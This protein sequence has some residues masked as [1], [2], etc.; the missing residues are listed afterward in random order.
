MAT[1]RQYIC[2]KCGPENAGSLFEAL[3]DKANGKL[4]HCSRCRTPYESLKLT[5][6]LGLGAK[7]PVCTVLDCFKPRRIESWPDGE[8]NKVKFYPFLVILQRGKKYAIWLPYWHRVINIKG[9]K[10]KNKYGQWAPL[11]YSHLFQ[12]LMQQ[13]REKGYDKILK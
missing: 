11:M 2:K 9:Q 8:E 10:S 13:A 4:L 7:H 5:F 6:D 1:I 12:N 3:E